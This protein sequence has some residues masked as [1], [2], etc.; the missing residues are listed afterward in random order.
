MQEEAELIISRYGLHLTQQLNTI[1]FYENE[2]IVLALSG[3]WKIQASIA[4]TFMIQ[5]YAPNFLINIWIAGSLK[6]EKAKIGDVFLIQK[7]S[8]HDL[9]LPFEWEH[10]SYAKDQIF[11]PFS[12]IFSE[13]ENK[14]WLHLDGF[15]LTGD[16]F[17]D[18]EKRVQQL[19]ETT[20]AD[21][22]EMEAFAFASTTRELGKLEKTIVIKAVSD[23]ANNQAQSAHMDN[24]E[25][26]MENSL[27][28]LEQ[29]IKQLP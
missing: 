1:R 9:Y 14:F 28:I 8:Q 15:C 5:N 29:I 18:D 19:Q 16:Q 22:V 25:F 2:T 26:A 24:L 4:T 6:G 10:L 20:Q 21:V 27:I 7:I 17:I 3:V 23:G 13:K 11:L 12:P